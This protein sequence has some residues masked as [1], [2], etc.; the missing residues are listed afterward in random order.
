MIIG[1]LEEDLI[2]VD[3][4]NKI[5]VKVYCR[6]IYNKQVLSVNIIRCLSFLPD[7]LYKGDFVVFKGR[8]E[9]DN[10]GNLELLATMAITY[11]KN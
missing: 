11:Q 1:T 10:K 2:K 9:V 7:F 3:D 6:D 4:S 8:I 5:S